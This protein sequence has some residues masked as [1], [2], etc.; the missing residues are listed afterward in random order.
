MAA[1]NALLVSG[2]TAAAVCKAA[3][4]TWSLLD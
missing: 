2:A 3:R 1:A 4:F